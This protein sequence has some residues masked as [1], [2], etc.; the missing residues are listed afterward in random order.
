MTC[1]AKSSQP[2]SMT[3]DSSTTH[4]V[5]VT[6]RTV[7]VA[8]L[9]IRH[10]LAERL[11]ALL[12]HENHLVVLPQTVVLR[13]S[14]AFRA[15]EP[16]PA[17]R[18]AYGDL[19]VQYVLA[20]QKNAFNAHI[21]PLR[22]ARG[23]LRHPRSLVSHLRWEFKRRDRSDRPEKIAGADLRMLNTRLTTL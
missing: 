14:M 12:A 19:R 21:L 5:V 11:L 7:L 18:S 13:F 20:G 15:V 8:L 6:M 23:P 17:A 3:A 2:T 9:V 4:V 10:V 16:L 1:S 22:T